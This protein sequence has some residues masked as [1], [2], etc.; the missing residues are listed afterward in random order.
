MPPWC[1]APMHSRLASCRG[2]SAPPTS[3]RDLA[4]NQ[5]RGKAWALVSALL[6]S[7]YPEA[8]YRVGR[9][10]GGKEALTP[11]PACASPGGRDLTLAL[12]SQHQRSHEDP[13]A[14]RFNFYD[15]VTTGP[16][17]PPALKALQ[18]RCLAPGWY[19]VHIERWLAHF[20]ASQVTPRNCPLLRVLS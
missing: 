6:T 20:A 12:P 17:A 15:V 7:F 11:T 5:P 9:F 19:A 13:A 1:P 16:Q 10:C 8:G 4:L 2:L 18:H 3:V 14:L